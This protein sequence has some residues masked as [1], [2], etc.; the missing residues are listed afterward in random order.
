MQM[1]RVDYM[2]DRL[3]DRMFYGRNLPLE[4]DKGNAV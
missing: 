3:I 2:S 1:K 4:K